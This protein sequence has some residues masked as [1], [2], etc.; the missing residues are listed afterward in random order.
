MTRSP[1]ASATSTSTPSR[2]SAV[3]LSLGAATFLLVGCGAT[4]PSNAGVK[5][6]DAAQLPVV[7]EDAALPLDAYVLDV[8]D[9]AELK[10][11]YRVLVKDCSVRFGGTPIVVQPGTEQLVRD[12]EMWSGRFGTMTLERASSL[13][14]HAGPD[15]VVA[16]S[17]GLFANESDEPLATILYGSD[18]KVIGEES[19]SERPKIPGLPEGG[20]T[21][22][23]IRKLG[24]DPLSTVPEQID[25]IRL[26]AYRDSR[27]QSAVQE[28]VACMRKGGFKYDAVDGPID[29]FSDGRALSAEE[30]S[31]ATAD[32]ECT[33]SSR[34]RDIS[35][36]IEAAY[37]EKELKENPE[38]WA[39]VKSNSEHIY[40][41]ARELITAKR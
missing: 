31:V 22:E 38:Q 7:T 12:S 21:G 11:M 16:P 40:E 32:V 13:G 35:F 18:R 30:I 24:G 29:T 10:E 33:R 27:T 2:S 17:F 5:I 8:G 19:G 26:R 36:A 23:V 15:D 9:L 1:H 34:W 28:W 37:Q 14:Y 39:A 3:A 6:P 20:C 4:D 25:K 41:A